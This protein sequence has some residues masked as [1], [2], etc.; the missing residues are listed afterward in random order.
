M[1]GKRF[2]IGDLTIDVEVPARFTCEY[3]LSGSLMGLDSSNGSAFELSALHIIAKDPAARGTEALVSTRENAKTTGIELYKDSATLAVYR[4]SANTWMGGFGSHLLV[5]TLTKPELVP[6][7]VE[8]MTSVGAA[9]DPFPDTK[10]VG[11]VDLR[12][13]HTRWFEQKRTSLLDSES[14]SPDSTNAPEKLDAFWEPPEEDDLL[15]AMLGGVTVGFGD[16]LVKRAG[17]QWC[18]AKDEWGTSLAVVA[19]RGTANVVIVPESF[20]AKR[21]E[22]K[23]P[24][25]IADAL[26]DIAD[27]VTKFK[28]EWKPN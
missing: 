15:S 26:A 16:L 24:K 22:R 18:V 28:A 23:E 17:F 3:S 5:A 7:F 14:W 13:S 6:E 11:I 2:A 25:F 21:W 9:H 27:H 10:D 12:P 19:L 8:V 20:V 4:E 1:T